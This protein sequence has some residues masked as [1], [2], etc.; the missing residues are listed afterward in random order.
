MKYL[1]LVFLLLSMVGCGE[2]AS[3]N[4]TPPV[5]TGEISAFDPDNIQP[6]CIGWSDFVDGNG[7][8]ICLEYRK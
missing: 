8:P 4:S 1:I 3:D 2:K 5:K 7:D 6:E